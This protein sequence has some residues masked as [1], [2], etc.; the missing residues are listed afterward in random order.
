MTSNGKSWIGVNTHLPNKIVKNA[1]I[2]RKIPEFKDY[3]K[4]EQEYKI[5]N[6]RIDL[7][8]SND[9]NKC[10]VEIK[11]V[12]LKGNKSDAIFPDA[13]T[14]RGRKHL[15][16][17]ITIK[18]SGNR[19]TMFFLVQREDVICFRPAYDIDPKYCKKLKE[20]YDSGVEILVYQT[21]LSPKEIKISKPLSFTFDN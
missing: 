2:E 13:V 14:N 12:T 17:L 3:S 16:D 7:F 4:V 21:S 20:A 19:A 9:K 5:E 11:N 15:E 6:S 10:F 18:K 8:L 1:I